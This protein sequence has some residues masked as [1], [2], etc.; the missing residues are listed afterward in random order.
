MRLPG[1]RVL[2]TRKGQHNTTVRRYELPDGRR[3]ST[4]E[5]PMS[6]VGSVGRKNMASIL[7]SFHRGEELRRASHRL[8]QR[9]EHMLGPDLSG[10]PTAI[11]HELGITET[12]VRQVRDEIR[13]HRTKGEP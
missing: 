11:A 8:R 3:V 4:I 7:E 2:S 13:Q 9:I 6:V 5:L 12:R 10:K 1:A